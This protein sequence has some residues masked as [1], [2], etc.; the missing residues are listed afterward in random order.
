MSSRKLRRFRSVWIPA[1]EMAKNCQEVCGAECEAD[2]SHIFLD[3]FLGIDADHFAAGIEQRAAAG[4]RVDGRIGLNPGARPG[5]VEAAN[6]TDDSLVTLKSM[7]SPGFADGQHVFSLSHRGG[8]QQ[9]EDAGSL[10]REFLPMQY[11]DPDRHTQSWLPIEC[12]SAA[13]RAT[14]PRRVPNGRLSQGR[15]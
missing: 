7:A 12:H 10:R 11:R 4:A 9:A 3:Q 6:G 14:L 2:A 13:S 8:P 1:I 15:P 5:S